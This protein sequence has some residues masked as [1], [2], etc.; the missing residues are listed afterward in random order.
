MFII[1]LYCIVSRQSMVFIHRD[2]IYEYAQIIG[3]IQDGYK[4]EVYYIS[5]DSNLLNLLYKLKEFMF[6]V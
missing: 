6:K 1:V 3:L 5:N 4:R 2:M